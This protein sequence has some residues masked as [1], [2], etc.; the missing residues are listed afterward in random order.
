MAHLEKERGNK[1]V[2][3][4][5]YEKAIGHYTAAIELYDQEP[6]YYTN[7]A[8]CYLKLAKYQLAI[9]DCNKAFALDK[10]FYKAYY[11]RMRS[12][13]MLEDYDLAMG[14]CIVMIKL[15]K[16]NAELRK[17]FDRLKA[18][19]L[20]KDKRQEDSIAAAAAAKKPTTLMW[21]PRPKKLWSKFG[22]DEEEIQFQDKAPHLRSKVNSVWFNPEKYSSVACYICYVSSCPGNVTN[23]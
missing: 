10:T 3:M 16:T 19:K 1:L 22:S 14:D 9:E 20:A 2:G 13:T 12:Y 6:A 7:R 21:Q 4:M 5:D 15:D 18:L 8:Q 11:R 23:V 17:E